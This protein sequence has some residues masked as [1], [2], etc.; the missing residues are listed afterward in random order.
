MCP[1]PHMREGRGTENPYPVVEGGNT[2]GRISG[3]HLIPLFAALGRGCRGLPAL[4]AALLLLGTLALAA[5]GGGDSNDSGGSNDQTPAAATQATP[6]ATPTQAA[7][8]AGELTPSGTFTEE[9]LI[10]PEQWES[11]EVELVVGD[12]VRVTY[13]SKPKAVGGFAESGA[14]GRPGLIFN[15]NDPIGDSIYQ[16]E[17]VADGGTEFTA[18]LNGTYELTFL[19]PVVRNLQEVQL[20]YHINP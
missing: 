12:I 4:V 2:I 10:L 9:E 1:G 5:C 18:E 13:T 8:A 14:L 11:F 17:Q 3:I 20:E 15:V 7:P 6:A 19:N 16:G